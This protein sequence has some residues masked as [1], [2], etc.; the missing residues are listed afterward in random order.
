VA[1]NRRIEGVVADNRRSARKL[2]TY[3]V[4]VDRRPS[5]DYSFDGSSVEVSV[6]ADVY[7]RPLGST[8]VFGH[9]DA[10]QGFGRG[11][12]GDQRDAWTLEESVAESAGEF[13]RL[14]RE[15]VADALEGALSG[16]DT[17]VVGSGTGAASPED[18][19]LGSR[20]GGAPAWGDKV[21]GNRTR[22]VGTFLFSGFGDAV[23][24]VG[25]E[26]NDGDLI[27]RLTTSGVNPAS[28]EEL[29]VDVVLEFAG[30]GVAD[31]VITDGS[32][33]AV[34][35]SMRS[36][37]DTVGLKE[38][39]IGTG[40]ASPSKSD[41][42]LA[43]EVGRKNAARGRTSERVRAFIKWYKDEPS[44]QPYDV[45]EM[46][47]FDNDGRLVFR[48]VFDAFTKDDNVAPTVGASIR[49]V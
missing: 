32:E 14:G 16:L 18:A 46:G 8:L 49:V 11:V 25:L 13:T 41:T 9:P 23:N 35:D 6:T 33:A 29:R 40:T 48:V 45:T 43:G 20:G 4:E 19:A 21:A 1:R 44:G 28:T 10:S 42:G 7:T 17:A 27:A 39:A 5:R 34:A 30:N 24:E 26:E 37:D 2:E 36:V 38:V 12:F 22:G 3:E 31:S 15:A 47:V